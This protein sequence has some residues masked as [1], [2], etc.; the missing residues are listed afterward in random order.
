MKTETLELVETAEQ[1]PQTALAVTDNSPA[2]MMMAAL[3]SGASLDHIEKMMDLQLR[4]EKREAEKAF[5]VD[6]AAF[7]G[8]NIII[9]KSKY[10]DR[11]RA[12]SFHQAEYDE[13]CRRI[14]PALSE[15]GLSFRHDQKFGSR[16]WTT[17]GVESDVPWVYVTCYLEHK[18][19]H[20]E[21]LTL[22]G[23]PGDLSANTATQNMQVTA[24]YL[25]RQSLLAI[26]GTATG[27]EDDE[28]KMVREQSG[29]PE[30]E[31]QK[32]L[33]DYSDESFAKNLPKWRVLI[34]SGKKSADAVIK[35]VSLVAVMS[36]EQMA[37]VRATVKQGET[38]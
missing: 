1:K 19:G 31:K 28:N 16:K 34:E 26:T 6:F 21:T 25:K 13:V 37:M 12:G 4:W 18:S 15:H 24:S 10:V 36:E 7:R 8:A 14:S 30:D 27:G 33:P 9:P 5:R 38:V 20:A 23:P 11:G 3:Q 17:D 2:G 29:A 35:N 22:E 32:V